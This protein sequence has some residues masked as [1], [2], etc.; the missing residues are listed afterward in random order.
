MGEA[1]DDL[2]C[3]CGANCNCNGG[4]D[5]GDPICTILRIVRMLPSDPCD[6]L[7]GAS[8]SIRLEDGAHL[9]LGR[10]HGP[11]ERQ[12]HALWIRG[13]AVDA[14]A[15]VRL[16]A[17]LD[18]GALGRVRLS[19]RLRKRGFALQRGDLQDGTTL[20]VAPPLEIP[21]PAMGRGRMI[22]LRMSRQAELVVTQTDMGSTGGLSI[23]VD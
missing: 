1:G 17:T 15:S 6:T 21:P 14:V 4:L 11:G 19:R 18:G 2:D 16:I 3:T 22:M 20:L 7:G 23:R 8:A 10:P 13:W 9:K 5:A 12:R